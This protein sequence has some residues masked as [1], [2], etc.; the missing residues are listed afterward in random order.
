ML[1]VVQLQD[2]RVLL[3][4]TNRAFIITLAPE[5]HELSRTYLGSGPEDEVRALAGDANGNVYAA[6]SASIS[7]RQQGFLTKLR[8]DGLRLATAGLDSAPASL[9][10]DS[11][12]IVHV[13][14]GE[15]IIKLQAKDGALR[16]MGRILA[17]G[18]VLVLTSD[19]EGTVYA[20]G[21]GSRGWVAKVNPSADSLAW[22]LQLPGDSG[23]D[24]VRALAVASDGSVWLAGQTAS[25]N[26]AS[27]TAA[28]PHLAGAPDAFLAKAAADGSML[29]WATYL[30]GSAQESAS[31]LA[32]LP[33]GRAALVGW[34]ASPDLPGTQV[35]DWAGWEDGFVAEFD[36]ARQLLHSIHIGTSGQDRLSCVL[37]G[38]DGTL[39]VGGWV[40]S[41][42]RRR[43]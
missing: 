12:G 39:W 7:G 42:A 32:L 23:Q 35:S 16:E 30:G 2:G 5:G 18:P 9:A 26:F 28:Q 11:A 25:T 13:A 19:V 1:A 6:W 43:T 27:S 20:G 3:G 14:T 41:G 36:S 8:P 15:L 34:T 24:A 17:P 4:G 40:G 10:L 37:L 33:G 31:G 38:R 22:K 21:A 29:E